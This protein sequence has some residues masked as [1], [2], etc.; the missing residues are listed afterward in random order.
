MNTLMRK[1]N[2][3]RISMAMYTKPMM[4]SKAV[5]QMLSEGDYTVC[6][7]NGTPYKNTYG[8]CKDLIELLQENHKTARYRSAY[9]KFLTR[10]ISV[11][12]K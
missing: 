11:L 8:L 4:P 3:K 1:E 10:C 12:L 5:R 7:G 9:L 6:T 2:L